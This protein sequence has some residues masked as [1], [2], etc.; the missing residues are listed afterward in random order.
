MGGG[1]EEQLHFLKVSHK[2]RH[3]FQLSNR[4]AKQRNESNRFSPKRKLNKHCL[5]TE[6][7]S[8][9]SGGEKAKYDQNE[10]P[11]THWLS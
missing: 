10:I 2:T 3:A 9:T 1:G 6:S 8:S 11:I 5:H 7:C 4:D